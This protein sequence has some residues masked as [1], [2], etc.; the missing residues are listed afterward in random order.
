[1]FKGTGLPVAAVIENLEDLS[2]EVMEQFDVTREQITAVLDFVAESTALAIV[3]L[4]GDAGLRTGEMR[5]LRWTDLDLTQGQIR[6]E[7]S[8]APR[9]AGACGLSREPPHKPGRTCCGTRAVR[10]WRRAACR[11]AR[12]RSWRG[13]VTSARR[14]DQF[15]PRAHA[16]AEAASDVRLAFEQ[17]REPTVPDVGQQVKTALRTP[18]LAQHSSWVLIV[19]WPMRTRLRRLASGRPAWRHRRY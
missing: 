10:T 3:L 13:I 16:G 11:R 2:T 17:K 14:S 18:T 7:C 1:V 4:G 15:C 8:D 5:A 6:V 19:A 9:N 12:S